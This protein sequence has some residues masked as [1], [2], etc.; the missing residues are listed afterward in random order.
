MHIHFSVFRSGREPEDVVWVVPDG[1]RFED[2][3]LVRDQ[4]G[5]HHVNSECLLRIFRANGVEPDDLDV[6]NE[7]TYA[8]LIAGWY[9]AHLAAGGQPDPVAEAARIEA[10]AEM[11]DQRWGVPGGC[12]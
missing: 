6:H 10:L 3:R 7:E 4:K 12:S 9:E 5:Y 11:I 8:S 2:L 1:V